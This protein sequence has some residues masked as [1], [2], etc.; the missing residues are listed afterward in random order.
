[1]R[2]LVTAASRHG[3]TDTIAHLI[4]RRLIEAGLD[5]DLRAPDDVDSID[6]VEAVVLGSAVY[7]GHWLA[8]A[9]EFARRFAAGLVQRPVFLFSSGPLGEEPFPTGDP[10][11]V[12]GLMG[13]TGA[14]EH[15]VFGGRLEPRDLGIVERLIVTG[16]HAPQGDFRSW[17]DIAAWAGTIAARLDATARRDA[18]AVGR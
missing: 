12:A 8:P 11:D 3:S 9:R 1:M 17:D 16:V 14:I 10:V 13:S 5:V 4:Q 6:G 7:T 18:V 15:R 2:V